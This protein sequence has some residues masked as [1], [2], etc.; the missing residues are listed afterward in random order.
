MA[1]Q[2]QQRPNDQFQNLSRTDD[3]ENDI[4]KNDAF[5]SGAATE[6]VAAY[7]VTA[8][9]YE[10]TGVAPAAAGGIATTTS[11]Y[12]YTAVYGTAAPGFGDANAGGGQ[13][14]QEANMGGG[15]GGA[16]GGDTGMNM[17]MG[18][19]QQK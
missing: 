15:G 8:Y 16:A 5:Q 11:R 19:N 13:G 17:N 7:P 14:G 4:Q 18:R 6:P 9:A 12:E 3:S 10:A 1:Q 2:Q